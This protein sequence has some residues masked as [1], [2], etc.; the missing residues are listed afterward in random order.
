MNITY[1]V[2][3]L[4]VKR[5]AE[6]WRKHYARAKELKRK[7]R[8]DPE[9]RRKEAEK[10]NERYYLN[11]FRYGE[12]C[13][14]YYKTHRGEINE[15]RKAW[16]RANPVLARELDK[17]WRDNSIKACINKFRRGDITLDELN[18]R[19]S[20]TFIRLDERLRS[21]NRGSSSL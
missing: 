18:R 10:A 16:R 1:T 17:K 11:K 20:E 12:Y 19:L 7:K 8:K 4:S 15:K 2:T 21:K 9:Y 14:G 6:G 3:G 5:T 13:R